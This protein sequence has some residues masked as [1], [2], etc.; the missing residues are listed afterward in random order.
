MDLLLTTLVEDVP[1]LLPSAL[2]EGQRA[3]CVDGL[4][5]V[6]ALLCDAQ[7]RTGLTR[8][9]NQLHI[10]SRLLTYKKNHV[11][12]QGA[13]TR[14]RTIVTWN[15][16]KI[17]LHSEKYQTA[18]EALRKLNS[19]DEMLVGWRVLKRD[20][21]R[22]ME[23]AEDLRKKEKQR[24]T[25]EAKWRAKNSEL[26]AHGMLPAELEDD[27]D[28]E[29]EDVGRGTE[30]RRQ[31]SWIWAVTGT[32][33]TDATLTSALQAEWSKAFARTWRWDEEVRLLNEKFRRV[34]ESFN[35]EERKWR[36]CAAAVP[37]SVLPRADAEAAVAYALRHADMFSDL[38][39]RGIKWWN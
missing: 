26:L 38:K 6:K 22:C 4:E 18:W 10:K 25:R 27:M 12:H 31:V 1:L 24:S 37:V 20:D 32:E 8:L 16:S 2:S 19:G 36:Q 3:R 35:H 17:R 34:C 39:E 9:R 15:E 7:C 5:H 13:N 21:I 14:S 33:G 29:E 23:D 28:D 30:N 11:W